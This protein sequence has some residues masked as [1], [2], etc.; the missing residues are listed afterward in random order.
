LERPRK[1]FH[2]LYQVLAEMEFQGVTID[3]DTNRALD[4][5]YKEHLRKLSSKIVEVLGPINLNSPTQLARALGE[6]VPGIDLSFYDI[7]RAMGTDDTEETSTKREVLEREAHKHPIIEIVLT[8]RK[9][10]VRYSTFVDKMYE[11]NISYHHKHAFLHGSFRTDLVETYRTSSS[12]PNTMN[13]P[14]KDDDNPHLSV[15]KQFVSRFKGGSILDADQSQIELRFAAWASGDVNMIAA[16]RSGEDIHTAMASRLLGKPAEEIT[17]RERYECKERTFL[18]MYGGGAKKLAGSLGVSREKAMHMIREYFETF[19]GLK[20]YIDSMH[21]IVKR[22]LE[23]TTHFGFKRRFAPPNRWNSGDGF[24]VMRQA[25]NTMIQNGAAC[26][27]YCGLIAV[28]N[29]LESRNLQSK[30]VL[31]VHDSMVL[32]VY[33]GEEEEVAEICK[34]GMEIATL[35]KAKQFGVDFTVPL[36]ADSKIG[37]NWAEVA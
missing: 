24:R 10:R 13:I 30:L 8:Y 37:P 32:D 27:M 12:S 16:I 20:R 33:P 14:V 19:S 23:V 36:E 26:L 15:K 17:E 18:I 2:E 22:D 5:L 6:A 21:A 4:Q 31:Q 25:F 35:E 1:L 3:V 34:T 11:N 7:R 29:A 28:H 9:Y